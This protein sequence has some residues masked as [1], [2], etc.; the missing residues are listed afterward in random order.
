MTMTKTTFSRIYWV[1][2]EDI[3]IYLV[4]RGAENISRL[5]SDS[6]KSAEQSNVPAVYLDLLK[7]L[8]VDKRIWGLA[9]DVLFLGCFGNDVWLYPVWNICSSLALA[10]EFN[11]IFHRS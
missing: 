7:I 3:C 8:N 5:K 4:G 1:C 6:L 10:N 11:K 2:T 9:I